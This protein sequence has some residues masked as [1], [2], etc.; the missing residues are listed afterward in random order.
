MLFFFL[1][2]AWLWVLGPWFLAL[3]ILV[4]GPVQALAEAYAF[5]RRKEEYIELLPEGI[6]I[7]PAGGFPLW[8]TRIGYE[9]IASA[10]LKDWWSDKVARALLRIFGRPNPPRVQL[11]FQQRRW[12]WPLKRL[13]VRPADPQ[14]LISALSARLG[15]A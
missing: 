9:A 8:I 11:R 4:L 13:Y 12:S 1:F 5:V 7:V 14:G 10:E 2:A 6:L 15:A 3:P